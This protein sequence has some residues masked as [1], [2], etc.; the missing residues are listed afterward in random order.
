[1]LYNVRKTWSDRAPDKHKATALIIIH[2]TPHH[3]THGLL[4]YTNTVS[5]DEYKKLRN[6]RYI[7]VACCTNTQVA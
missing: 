7:E 6:L 3:C 1:L 2:T 4:K 5:S